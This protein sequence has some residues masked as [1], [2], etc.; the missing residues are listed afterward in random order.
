MKRI[1]INKLITAF[2]ISASMATA[3]NAI[4]NS[5]PV[6]EI[7]CLIEPNTVV[8]L[9]SPVSGVL[10]SINVDRS[11]I[12]K[13]NA[14][15]A[16]LK[17]DIEQLNVKTSRENLKLSKK[18]HQRAAELYR[19]KAITLSEKEKA[20]HEKV[21]YELELR[22]ALTTLELRNIRSPIDGV[23][24][25]RFKMPGEYVEDK[26]ILKIAQLDPLRIE[27]VSP[28]E[29]FGL[30][31]KGMHA[32]IKPEYGDFDELIAEIVLVDQVIDA[33]SGTFGIRLELEN[34]GNK[35]PGG[36]KCKVRFFAS[37]EEAAYTNKSPSN[38][39]E[40]ELVAN[41]MP[42]PINL[43]V[44]DSD[45]PVSQVNKIV[46][47]ALP[48]VSEPGKK[49]SCYSVGK[50]KNR[51][52]LIDL[53]ESLGD[54][55]IASNIRK[56]EAIGKTHLV[57]TANQESLEEARVHADIIGQYEITDTSIIPR[58]NNQYVIA[59]GL[60]SD[61]ALAEKHLAALQE[62]GIDSKI[63]ARENKGEVY[64]ADL[65]S[66]YPVE[67]LRSLIK[68]KSLQKTKK[69]VFQDCDLNASGL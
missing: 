60:F 47:S 10:D 38:Q 14:I 15:V 64:W 58:K 67:A 3:A 18:E 2:A 26:P 43:P 30:I 16:T 17:S 49:E 66:N 50:F 52:E 31:K 37:E 35:I 1:L 21:L 6:P 55:V 29:N 11:D 53:I 24:V 25:D 8:N 68:A 27:V 13:K 33:A 7:D 63:T 56:H 5:S 57:S 51:E 42:V 22:N 48:D 59:L 32:Q 23:V 28:V 4:A 19:E 20:D 34:K 9:S 61:L 46:K 62:Y 39:E 65:V 41:K 44:S 45:K 12:V 40:T 36:L 69:L 54:D